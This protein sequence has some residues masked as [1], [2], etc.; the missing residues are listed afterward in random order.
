[1]L[2][3]DPTAQV[4]CD[5]LKKVT[6]LLGYEADRRRQ[7]LINSPGRASDF[8]WTPAGCEYGNRQVASGFWPWR[9]LVNIES[10]NNVLFSI[11][12]TPEAKK[13]HSIRT[14]LQ[15][16][17]LIGKTLSELMFSHVKNGAY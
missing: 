10:W 8:V 13:R 15:A 3:C 9:C 11:S 6:L 17:I 16:V 14:G 12:N 5:P 1:M 4:L 2:A 7:A